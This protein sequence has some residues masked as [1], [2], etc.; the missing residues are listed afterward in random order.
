MKKWV[1]LL[2]MFI[3]ATCSAGTSKVFPVTGN[4]LL[5]SGFE[6]YTPR[7]G[8]GI[9]FWMID[10][11]GL[12]EGG[13]FKRTDDVVYDAASAA[14]LGGDYGSLFHGFALPDVEMTIYGAR[15][16]IWTTAKD[17]NPEEAR[18]RPLLGIQ[19]I[20]ARG[21]LSAFPILW[22][23]NVDMFRSH[24]SLVSGPLDNPSKPA[25]P[26]ASIHISLLPDEEDPAINSYYANSYADNASEVTQEDPSGVPEPNTMI[27][28]GSGLLVLAGIGRRF[29]RT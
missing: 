5:N 23:T 25:A 14:Y 1:R 17:V 18:I 24:W 3:I 21:S 29:T 26:V 12:M 7:T 11:N 10:S 22:N 27:L 16:R 28:L 2:L 19:N 9:P 15:L 8:D 13:T 20:D 4:L 6:K